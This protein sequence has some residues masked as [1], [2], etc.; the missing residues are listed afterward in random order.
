MKF[1]DI[2]EKDGTLVYTNKGYSMMPWI[3]EGKDVIIIDKLTTNPKK[4]DVVFFRRPGIVGRGEYVLHRVM[5]II[6]DD[7]Y[8]IIGDNTMSGEIVKKENILGILTTIKQPTKTIKVTDK[9]FIIKSK[10]WWYLVWP[11]LTLF[12]YFKIFIKKMI[13]WDKI[14]KYIKKD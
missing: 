6:D 11:L 9:D 14:K 7:T 4:W 10:L 13:F 8:Y 12:R 2:L 3:H 1:E 5:R